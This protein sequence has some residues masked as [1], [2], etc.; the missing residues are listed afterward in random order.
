MKKP[1]RNKPRPIR[2][3]S[4]MGLR[5]WTLPGG[6]IKKRESLVDALRREVREETALTAEVG[7]LLA[8][9]DRPDRDTLTLLFAASR[10]V[11]NSG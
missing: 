10:L 4:V 2:E 8:V 3:V 7:G 11:G 6:K 5:T 1:A 9:F